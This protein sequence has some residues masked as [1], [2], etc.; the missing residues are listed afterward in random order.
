MKY[1]EIKRRLLLLRENSYVRTAYGF[2]KTI[3]YK[4]L[5]RTIML[6]DEDVTKTIPEV[7]NVLLGWREEEALDEMI[8]LEMNHMLGDD[9]DG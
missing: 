5:Q 3:Q 1:S 4:D 8:E 6:H 7:F 2:G 9:T